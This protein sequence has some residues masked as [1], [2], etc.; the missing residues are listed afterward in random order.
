MTMGIWGGSGDSS[1]FFIK[2]DCTVYVVDKIGHADFYC[3]SGQTDRPYDE[4]HRSLSVS[5]DVL[6]TGA[7]L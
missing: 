3:C 1:V 5:K 7:D 2:P 4:R 6:D